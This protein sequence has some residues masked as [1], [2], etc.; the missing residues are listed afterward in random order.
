MQTVRQTKQTDTGRQT[1]RQNSQTHRQNID[2]Q[3]GRQT[4]TL[5]QAYI[6]ST[7]GGVFR[8]FQTSCFSPSKIFGKSTF[9][10]ELGGKSTVS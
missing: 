10:D 6:L 9:M 5:I 1:D 7:I 2:I 4:D 8:M 3:T